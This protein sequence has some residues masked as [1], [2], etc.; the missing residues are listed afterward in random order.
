MDTNVDGQGAQVE[1]GGSQDTEAGQHQQGAVDQQS[2]QTSSTESQPDGQQTAQE[3]QQ[4]QQAQPIQYSEDAYAQVNNFITSVEGDAEK[5]TEYML[6]NGTLPLDFTTKLAEKHGHA[7]A[8][9]VIEQMKAMHESHVLEAQQTSERNNKAVFDQVHKAFE[10]ITEQTGEQSWNELATWAKDNVP[11]EKRDEI[12]V[13]LAQGGMSAE[14]A[15]TFLI[16][17]FKGSAQ[18]TQP[19]QLMEGTNR[20]NVPAGGNLTRAEYNT[21]LNKL[22]DAGKSYNSSEVVKLQAQRKRSMQ[23]GI[24]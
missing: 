18:Y 9:L 15:V 22:L 12:N 17:S 10:G 8:N 21:K 1:Q 6:T 24:N 19:A 16:D 20:N 13:M 11:K 5:L 23:R 2:D 3:E 7:T 4:E 14:L